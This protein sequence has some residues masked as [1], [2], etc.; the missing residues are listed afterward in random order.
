VQTLESARRLLASPLSP[1][2]ICAIIGTL[3]FSTDLQVL[4]REAVRALRLSA[5]ISDAR[6]ARGKGALRALVINTDGATDLRTILTD[7]AA[8]LAATVAH[9][10]W[11]LVGVSE[12]P[13]R[14]ALACW[15]G[16]RRP[17][18]VHALYCESRRVLDSDAET[19]CALEAATGPSDM[20]THARWIDILGR[21]GITRRFFGA[22]QLLIEEM[23]NSPGVKGSITERSDLA[24]LH[25]S[26]LLFLSFL[27]TRG[28]L[29]GDFGF[30]ANGYDS[31]VAGR[32]NYQRRVLE[33]LFFG[34][35]NTR[36]GER[37]TRARQF[38]NIP[39]LNGGLFSR[40]PLEKRMRECV[41]SD[42]M[43]GELFGRLLSRYRFTAR[44]DA[45]QWSETA[46]DPEILGKAFE[47]L[48]AAP[49]R[50]SSGA[51][52]TPQRLVED[53]V[54]STLGAALAENSGLGRLRELRVLDPACGSG[55][56]LVQMLERLAWL[57][58]EA[59]DDLPLHAVR[60]DV[61][62]TA[63]FGVDINPTAVWLCELRLWL[64]I[65]VDG[66]EK[67]PMRVAPLPNLDRNIR[68]G[69]SLAGGAFSGAEEAGGRRLKVMRARY[70]RATGAR[71]RTLCRALDR[72]ERR[73]AEAL[74]VAD[75]RAQRT[76][77]AEMLRAARARDLF[78][79]RHHPDR[80]LRERVL[81]ARQ[82]QY[83][84]TAR[85]RRLREGG[86]LPFTF[87]VHFSGIAERRGFDVVIGN[88][89]WVRIHH[90]PAAGREAM[91]REF[92]VYRNAAWEQ[93]ARGA[94]AGKG[95]GGQV[96]AASLFVERS[97]QLVRPGGT[98]GLLVPAK[99]WHSLAGG[100]IRRLLLEESSV[101]GVED[102]SDAPSAFDAAVYPATVVARKESGAARR[103]V[104][105]ADMAV[106]RRGSLAKWCASPRSLPLDDSPGS[107]WLL[108]PPDVRRSFDRVTA[109]GIPL[110]LSIFGRPLLGAKTGCNAAYLV[111]AE[112]NEGDVTRVAGGEIES[113]V[114]R[115]V[116]RGETL[117]RW[118]HAANGE[119][120]IWPHDARGTS[121]RALPPLAERWLARW[122][123]SLES[124]TDLHGT[125]PWWTLFR[126]ESAG[127]TLARVIWADFGVTLRAIA[128][129]AGDDL[130]PLNSCYSL[131]CPTTEDARAM[132]V[133]LNSSLASAWLNCIAEPARG[134]YHRYLGWTLALLPIPR[135]WERARGI[136]APLGELA[137]AGTVPDDAEV[138]RAA[139]ESYGMSI[140]AVEELLEWDSESRSA[141]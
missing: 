15:S 107:P 22:L 45:T 87:G 94:G 83:A 19:L 50:K 109:A 32:G 42:E 6:V 81:E 74:L 46:I 91:R 100:G 76:A 121:L 40:S 1:E 20:L 55:A 11:I 35:L 62:S 136:L 61:L 51:F 138:Q 38:G 26:R 132:S 8:G 56:F 13:C 104:E 103:D 43:F 60:R 124:R 115:A 105:A 133:I 66:G 93:G 84:T 30:L 39:F 24:L 65:V 80:L 120:I 89:P 139:L 48:M 10:L 52:Y 86:A 37:S 128:V 33:P 101:V 73:R 106:Y 92:S 137:A 47:A 130:V 53:L 135:D 41:F 79:D 63:I 34:T 17:P 131:K 117:F 72:E 99:L 36:V 29:N 110:A 108:V 49:E 85:L 97:L 75:Q 111:N 129:S 18:R 82:K 134:G 102:L 114:L 112:R 25:V 96:D 16:E 31:C 57:R 3:G 95:F 119:R 88:P 70:G 122:R 5:R 71:K 9:Q 58:V 7:S 64:A 59:G 67:N 68:V 78:G 113:C 98:V 4:D 21:E 116:V 23:S 90:I 125:A 28:W 69:D 12:S 14:V 2:S 123:R 77:R 127:C 54:E 126:T 118:R 140:E 44:E 141:M 27:E